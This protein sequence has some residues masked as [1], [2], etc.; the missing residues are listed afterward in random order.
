M[1]KLYIDICTIVDYNM[2][3]K[4]EEV[5]EKTYA[6]NVRI[7]YE[8][9]YHFVCCRYS[10]IKVRLLNYIKKCF[11]CLIMPCDKSPIYKGYESIHYAVNIPRHNNLLKGY[12]NMFSNDTC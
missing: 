10:I 7:L 3:F 8:I 9:Q 11:I 12:T 4:T 5:I 6:N 2:Y 1:I